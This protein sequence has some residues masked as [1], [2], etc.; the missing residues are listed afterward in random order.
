MIA[1]PSGRA[2]PPVDMVTAGAFAKPATRDSRRRSSAFIAQFKGFA[3]KP[4]FTLAAHHPIV[5]CRSRVA[6]R[7]A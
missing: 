3:V 1:P 4:I 7:V 2:L 5:G 6:D